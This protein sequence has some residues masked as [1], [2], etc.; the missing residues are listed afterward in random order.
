MRRI[1]KAFRMDPGEIFFNTRMPPDEEGQEV[2]RLAAQMD[3]DTR[4]A[5]LEV[6]ET[7]LARLGSL[8]KPGQRKRA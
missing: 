4:T 1:G 7:L 6:G 5:W 8:R 2:L 3:E